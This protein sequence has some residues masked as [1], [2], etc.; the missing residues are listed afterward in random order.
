MHILAA[1]HLVTGRLFYRPL[2]VLLT[3]DGLSNL[4]IAAPGCHG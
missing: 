1:L 3:A 4:K 2:M